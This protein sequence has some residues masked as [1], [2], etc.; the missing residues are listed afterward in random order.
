MVVAASRL[1]I[2]RTRLFFRETKVAGR[3]LSPFQHAIA[4]A[5]SRRPSEGARSLGKDAKAAFRRLESCV[6]RYA[7]MGNLPRGHAR[8]ESRAPI[9]R[10]SIRVSKETQRA[11][12]A[13]LRLLM[14]S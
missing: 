14:A 2:L 10:E 4:P 12:A 3:P 6:S 11:T 1:L 8:F 5:L 9:L 7:A 13:Y